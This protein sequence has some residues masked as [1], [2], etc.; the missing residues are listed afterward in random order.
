VLEEALEEEEENSM[1]LPMQLEQEDL[2]TLLIKN[3]LLEDL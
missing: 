1:V 3:M 2:F